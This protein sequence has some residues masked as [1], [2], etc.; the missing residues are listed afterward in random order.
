MEPGLSSR[1]RLMFTGDLPAASGGQAHPIAGGGD[2]NGLMLNQ[3]IHIE[4][5]LY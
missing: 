1:E 3:L 4:L 2:G 5:E